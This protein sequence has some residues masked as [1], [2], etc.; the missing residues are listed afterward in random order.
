MK[1]K[2]IDELISQLEVY[3]ENWKQIYY[4]INLVRDRRAQDKKHFSL[5]EENQFLDVKSLIA[6]QLESILAYFADGVQPIDKEEIFNVITPLSSLRV[7]SEINEGTLRGIENQWHK[8]FIQLQSLLGQLK[9]QRQQTGI[10]S[11]FSFFSKNK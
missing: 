3:I 8:I 10:K 5:E 6:Q 2:K 7:I 4:F 11:F 9:V 1:T